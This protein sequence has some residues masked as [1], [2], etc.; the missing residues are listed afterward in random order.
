MLSKNSIFQINS[1]LYLCRRNDFLSNTLKLIQ[2]YDLKINKYKCPQNTK[3]FDIS[4]YLACLQEGCVLFA[5][6]CVACV[7]DWLTIFF[8]LYVLGLGDS[9]YTF[10]CNGGKTVDRL[11]QELGAQHFYDTGLAD[12][13]VG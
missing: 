9:E 8:S 6:L 12:D 2:I 11:L 10:F 7:A 3:C 1:A 5:D 13:C 4:C